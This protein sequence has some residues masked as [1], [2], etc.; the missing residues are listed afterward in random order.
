MNYTFDERIIK[1]LI[2]NGWYPDRF[3]NIDNYR[4]LLEEKN[5]YLNASAEKF[6]HILGG[7]T[8][9]HEAYSDSNET[10][11]SEFNPVKPLAWLDPKW[12]SEYYEKIM[13]CRDRVF[14]AYGL[15]CL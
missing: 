5:Y 14:R 4:C 2:Q 12:V 10:D 7:L 15:L 6:F 13:S 11:I 9:I 1:I 8:I 3:I